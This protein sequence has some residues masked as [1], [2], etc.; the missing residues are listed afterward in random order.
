MGSERVIFNGTLDQIKEDAAACNRIG[1]HELFFDPTF[2]AAAQS[3][4][5]WLTLMERLRKLV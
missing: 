2:C 3:L 5:G 1:A 4:E